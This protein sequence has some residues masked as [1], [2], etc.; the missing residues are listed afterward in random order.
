MYHKK[1]LICFVFFVS[2]F[3]KSFAEKNSFNTADTNRVNDL[4]KKGYNVVFSSSEETI[5]YGLQAQKMAYSINYKKGI[6]EAHRIIGIAYSYQN[7]I[8]SAANNYF[9]ALSIFQSIK[10]RI[11]EAKVLNN[12]GYLYYTFDNSKSL[13]YYSYSLRLAKKLK[14]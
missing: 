1:K 5:K 13:D 6:G 11:S 10:D 12:I 3:I 9:K 8:D 7:Q 2:F 14:I 4:N